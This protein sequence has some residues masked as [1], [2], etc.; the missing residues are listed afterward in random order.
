MDRLQGF[1]AL[2]DSIGYEEYL[3]IEF[4][5]QTLDLL[6]EIAL[7]L[8]SQ[9]IRETLLER[10]NDDA[11]SNAIITHFRVRL[12]SNAEYRKNVH[13]QLINPPAYHQW[14][15]EVQSTSLQGLPS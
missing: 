3:Y 12:I 5:Q 6:E 13:C 9:G 8:S 4:V 15:D 14:M 7:N 1:N 10:F 11:V 2:I